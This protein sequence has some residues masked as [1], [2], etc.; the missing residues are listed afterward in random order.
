MGSVKRKVSDIATYIHR[1]SGPT[2]RA[3]IEKAI[4]KRD[5]TSFI[6]VCRRAKVPKMYI[7]SL[8]LAL[9][10]ESSY[11]LGWPPEP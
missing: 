3:D 6:K 9:L 11:P 10:L 4:A 7:V 5:E 2:F 1:L 8:A